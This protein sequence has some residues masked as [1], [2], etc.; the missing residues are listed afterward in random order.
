M[1][2]VAQTY[3]GIA[4]FAIF[5]GLVF[6]GATQEGSPML[7]V[8]VGVILALAYVALR[9]YLKVKWLQFRIER[10]CTEYEY[11]REMVA[12]LRQCLLPSELAKS[13]RNKDDRNRLVA[14]I[15]RMAINEVEKSM[16]RV[17]QRP[18]V[19]AL[20]TADKSTPDN[21]K[22]VAWSYGAL[23]TR[24]R[25]SPGLPI[26]D[27]LAGHVFTTGITRWSNDFD[28][29]P[30]FEKNVHPDWM[31]FYRSGILAPVRIMN[32]VTVGVFAVDCRETEAFEEALCPIVEIGAELIGLALQLEQ[33]SS[34]DSALFPSRAESKRL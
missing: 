21:L 26:K 2:G 16:S 9:Y 11:L 25:S 8:A 22:P 19:A 6:V 13:I 20:L 17:I 23:T 34:E 15:I 30:D 3:F 28:T 1:R 5:I 31:Q 29:E 18:C 32:D 27:T 12:H 14:A 33:L 4:I 10:V 7:W 24:K